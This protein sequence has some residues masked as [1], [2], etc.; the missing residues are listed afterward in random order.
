MNA[1]R[2]GIEEAIP[3]NVALGEPHAR[4][5]THLAKLKTLKLPSR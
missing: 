1:K 2:L 5:N 4:S 3:F